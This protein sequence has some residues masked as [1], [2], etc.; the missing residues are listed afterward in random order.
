MVAGGLM[1]HKNV[2]KKFETTPML[3]GTIFL[4]PAVRAEPN[5]SLK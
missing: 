2:H 3:S 1:T 5:K 4:V